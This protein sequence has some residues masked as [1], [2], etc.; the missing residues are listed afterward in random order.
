MPLCLAV[1]PPS[2][3]S[4]FLCHVRSSQQDYFD[5]DDDDDDASVNPPAPGGDQSGLLI[6]PPP[7]GPTLSLGIP[8]APAGSG[9]G[10]GPGGSKLPQQ[11][12]LPPLL[13]GAPL[14]P[15]R[16]GNHAGLISLGAGGNGGPGPGPQRPVNGAG[17]GGGGGHPHARG[18]EPSVRTGSDS[19]PRGGVVVV[20]APHAS[21]HVGGGT[22][23]QPGGL[24]LRLVDYGDDENEREGEGG[25]DSDDSMGEGGAGPGGA[26]RKRGM[27][28]TAAAPSDADHGKRCGPEASV[29]SPR[30]SH[31]SSGRVERKSLCA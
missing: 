10:P 4:P 16:A 7:L 15:P 5:A 1:S 29:V 13:G 27:D 9:P 18:S 26:V 12:K 14:S 17:G 28:W 19:P 25:A 21:A 2:D 6:G 23:S 3:F 31:L 11:L 30:H 20:A 22:A 8:G 24:P